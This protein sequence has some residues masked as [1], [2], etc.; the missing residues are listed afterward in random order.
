MGLNIPSKKD[1][2]QKKLACGEKMGQ[3][4]SI[5]NGD[6]DLNTRFNCDWSNLLNH[7]RGTVEINNSLVHTQLKS[8][9]CVGAWNKKQVINKGFITIN[10][11]TIHQDIKDNDNTQ[12]QNIALTFS[13]SLMK[14]SK[15][16]NCYQIS[17]CRVCFL[18]LNIF[19]TNTWTL[20]SRH[21]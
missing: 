19:I 7:I 13:A 14:F 10:I 17:W 20:S 8:V 15:I 3:K 16:T 21:S 11:S 18:T 5:C 4:S 9:P 1:K 12:N 2:L 6:L